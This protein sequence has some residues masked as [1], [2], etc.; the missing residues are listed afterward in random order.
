MLPCFGWRLLFSSLSQCCGGSEPS[1]NA[2]ADYRN[3]S[4]S[5]KAIWAGVCNA[6]S[7][8]C[9]ISL[10]RSFGG[11]LYSSIARLMAVSLSGASIMPTNFAGVFLM[12]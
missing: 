2:L 7:R 9:A 8:C 1:S 11:T 12:W 5:P 3:V 10:A 4:L 6:Q